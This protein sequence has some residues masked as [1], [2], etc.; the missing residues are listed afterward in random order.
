MNAKQTDAKRN[1]NK[2]VNTSQPK[3]KIAAFAKHLN[4][5]LLATHMPQGN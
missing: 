2:D 3:S 4:K 5:C 1:N